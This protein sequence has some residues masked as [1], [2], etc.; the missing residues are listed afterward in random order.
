[1]RRKITVGVLGVATL[2]L[3]LL[4]VPASAGAGAGAEVRQ[5][6]G[7]RPALARFEGRVI[8]LAE[9]W[10]EAQACLVWRQG[11]V[12]ECFRTNEELDAREAEL[13]P[14]RAES[15][16][17]TA[18]YTIAAYS[19]S[20]SVRLYE[21]DWYGGRRLSYWDRGY[22]Q[23]LSDYGFEDQLSSYIVGGCPV[24]L[25]EHAWGGGNWYWGPTYPYAA[26]PAMAWDWQN[27]VSSIYIG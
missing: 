6:P 11:G 8:N 25:A 20:S 4:A 3:T 7:R 18:D 21:Y 9:N 1:V 15:N 2:L 19:C 12:L 13:A 26:E 17:V 27:T 24:W 10:G 5:D 16:T 23:N 14:R 22:W